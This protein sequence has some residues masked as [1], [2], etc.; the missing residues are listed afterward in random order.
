MGGAVHSD[1]S[2]KQIY[3]NGPCRRAPHDN[4][5]KVKYHINLFGPLQIVRT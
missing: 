3:Y 4:I 2:H 1:D 5:W